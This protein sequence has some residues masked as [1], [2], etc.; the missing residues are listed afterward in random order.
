VGWGVRQVVSWYVGWLV[1][2]AVGWF[3]GWKGLG[4]TYG[5]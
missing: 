2:D 3:V 1:G 4:V 5:Y